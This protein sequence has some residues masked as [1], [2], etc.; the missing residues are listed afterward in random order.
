MADEKPA[1]PTPPDAELWNGHLKVRTPGC[2][3]MVQSRDQWTEYTP[4]IAGPR[5]IA[6][7]ISVRDDAT[8]GVTNIPCTIRV[9]FRE[10][11]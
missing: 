10:A 4:G 7:N 5:E 3:V 6:G 8:Q 9:Q 11:K 2:S 1:T